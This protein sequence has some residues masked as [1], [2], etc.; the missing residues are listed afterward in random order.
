MYRYYYV[1]MK[2]LQC[3]LYIVFNVKY[4]MLYG[5]LFAL[6]FSFA[7]MNVSLSDHYELMPNSYNLFPS[8]LLPK[9]HKGQ[10]QTNKT[11]Q[12]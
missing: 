8:K 12:N 3:H 1:L 10:V 6:E 2:F 7:A 11:T 9:E 5:F 4:Q